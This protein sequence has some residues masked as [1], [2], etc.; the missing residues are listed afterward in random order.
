MQPKI[1]ESDQMILV[2]LG[3]YGDPFSESAG[4]TEENEIGRLW[5]RL[6]TY[7]AENPTAIQETIG[8]DVAYEVHVETTETPST[9][10]REV[11]VGVEVERLVDLPV[12][13]SAKILP[14]TKY[15]IFTLKGEQIAG[16]WSMSI[17]EWMLESPYDP[18]GTYGIQ[19]YDE[20]FRGLDELAASELDIYVPI[21][22]SA[23]APPDRD[24]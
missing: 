21:K 3:F 10:Y 6:M 4:W 19:R 1:V 24:M 8:K 14:A 2:G 20:R 17:G 11:F 5:N 13:L 23:D 16:D 18:V 22:S 15:A 7:L 9:G 12:E